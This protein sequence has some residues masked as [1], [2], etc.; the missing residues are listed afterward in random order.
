MNATERTPQVL[1]VLPGFTVSTIMDVV[2]PL[3]ALEAAGQIHFRA[4]LESLS[5]LN[6]I[7]R[8]DYVVFSRNTEP[9]YAHFLEAV[10]A[11]GIPFI[12]DLDDNFF[13]VPLD[14]EIGQYH[15]DPQRLETLVWYLSAADLVRVYSRPL[16]ERVRTYNSNVALVSAPLDWSLI[17]PSRRSPSD[18][19][20]RIVYPTSRRED[21]LF[22]VFS[23]ALRQIL[24]EH[25]GEVE[26][27]FWGAPVQGF[28]DLPN[29]HFLKF[30][31]NYN[32]YLKRFSEMGFDIG[33]A[34]LIDNE[35]YRSKTNNKFREYGACRV[36][37]VYSQVEVYTACIEDGATG[38]LVPNQPQ[39]W[40]D[41][42]QRLIR[43]APMRSRISQSAY[44]AVRRLYAQETFESVWAEQIRRLSARSAR[45]AAPAATAGRSARETAPDA[46]PTGRLNWMLTKLRRTVSALFQ[47][48]PRYVFNIIWAQRND[49]WF[50]LKTNLFKRI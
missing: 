25:R 10:R 36:A 3:L 27:Y 50:L 29:V 28:E 8:A 35:F 9:K 46:P 6:T 44:E 49:L 32:S 19:R 12:Y 24:E 34:P 45:T 47:Q 21:R 15:R 39:A 38:L 13:E 2:K 31:P 23:P 22:P 7:D 26:M 1:A 33:L 18:A 30:M 37:G 42:I 17:H 11:R 5:L 48:G 4:T 16:Q 20:V 40:Y 14:T 41:A 43:D